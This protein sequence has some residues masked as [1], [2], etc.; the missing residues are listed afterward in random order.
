[1]TKHGLRR[2]IGSSTSWMTWNRPFLP[3]I[4]SDLGGRAI[5]CHA[6]LRCEHAFPVADQRRKACLLVPLSKPTPQRKTQ[7]TTKMKKQTKLTIK[8]RPFQCAFLLAIAFLLNH[9][10]PPAVGQDETGCQP[11]PPAAA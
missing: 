8:A 5:A 2:C 6:S 11:L 3:T 7:R 1:M 9:V 4:D 10:T